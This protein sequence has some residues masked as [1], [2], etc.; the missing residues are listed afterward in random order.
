MN[1]DP[2]VWV[3]P[4]GA[5]PLEVR[6]SWELLERRRGRAE[7]IDLEALRGLLDQ[8]RPRAAIVLGGPV[9]ADLLDAQRWLDEFRVATLVVV[10]DLTP[11]FEAALLERGAR[12]VVSS[13]TAVRILAARFEALLR[14]ASGWLVEPDPAAPRLHIDP[15]S[16]S[17]HLG[18]QQVELTRAEF[19]LLLTLTRRPGVFVTRGALAIELQEQTISRRALESRVSRLR[20]KLRAHGAGEMVETVRS[21]GYRFNPEGTS[22]P[23]DTRPGLGDEHRRA[24]SPS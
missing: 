24:P 13:S 14:H 22:A 4:V 11:H 9:S 18:T 5:G 12:D 16:R 8:R 10:D 15:E 19:D 2:A 20:Q 7:V 23:P 17:V 21:V 1:V 3:I 6:R